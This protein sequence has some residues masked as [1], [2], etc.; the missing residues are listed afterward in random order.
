MAIVCSHITDQTTPSITA[1]ARQLS[2]SLSCVVGMEYVFRVVE[3][4]DPALLLERQS[5]VCQPSECPPASFVRA[6]PLHRPQRLRSR[7]PRWRLDRAE[8]LE[9]WTGNFE[10]HPI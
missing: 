2:L 6:S 5:L 10:H 3:R 8:G 4:H 9:G 1:Q 7:S